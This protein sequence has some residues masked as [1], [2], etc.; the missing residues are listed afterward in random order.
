VSDPTSTVLER[1][2]ACVERWSTS[3]GAPLGDPCEPGSG[4]LGLVPAVVP[5]LADLRPTVLTW[6]S[7]PGWERAAVS[8]LRSRTLRWVHRYYPFV[9]LRSEDRDEL[10]RTYVELLEGTRDALAAA[11]G[12]GELGARLTDLVAAW[13]AA[14]TLLVRSWVAPEQGRLRPT[15]SAEYSPELQL[16]I[17]GLRLEELAEPILDL[18][19]GERAHL[20]RYLRACGKAAVGI[21]R[22]LSVEDGVRETDWFSL[23]LVPDS[24]GTVIAHQSFSLHFLHHHLGSG[25]EPERYARR[26]RE[27]LRAVRRGGAF[28][29]APGLPFLEPLL[30]DREFR[31]ERRMVSGIPDEPALTA[32]WLAVLGESPLYACRVERTA[33]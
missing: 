33:G 18:G 25:P 19:C 32:R 13:Q 26:Y 3:Q 17:L 8:L 31:V 29:Y 4:W 30:S 23:P 15:V 5:V 14:F 20:V 28:V 16:T 27:I 6:T 22:Y 11:C 9:E 10:D 21:D 12:P 2:R 1:L 7:N 24:W